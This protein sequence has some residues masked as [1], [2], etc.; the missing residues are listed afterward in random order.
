MTAPPVDAVVV[1]LDP[2]E[3]LAALEPDDNEDD[4]EDEDDDEDDD[5]EQAATSS[6]RRARAATVARVRNRRR[7]LPP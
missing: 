2:L 4:N 7:E 3:S 6:G 1:A 5:G